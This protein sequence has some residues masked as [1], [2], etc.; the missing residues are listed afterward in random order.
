MKAKFINEDILDDKDAARIA[1]WVNDP[2]YENFEK[3][4]VIP[5]PLTITFTNNQ[6]W[7]KFTMVLQKYRIPFKEM[8]GVTE[9]LKFSDG[10]EFDTSGPLRPEK[11]Y[12]GWYVI[13]EG[14]LIPVDS[15][16]EADT[17]IDN[18]K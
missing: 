13:G 6:D 5:E 15:K 7:A 14:K 17:Y 8:E 10:E 1:N 16:E 4:V 12:D 2:R 11:R 9:T 3:T 18:A